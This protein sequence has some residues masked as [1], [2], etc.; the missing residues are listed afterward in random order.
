MTAAYKV[1]GIPMQKQSSR[2]RLVVVVYAALLLLCGTSFAMHLLY[3]Q[4]ALVPYS[5]AIYGSL[6]V[7]AFLFG[8][9]GGF[10]G[11][12]GLVKPFANKPPRVEPPIVTLVKLQ[13]QPEALLHADES[14]WRNDERELHRRDRA[15]YQAYQAVGIGVVV[16][17]LLA[18]WGL[19]PR[20][21]VI[22]ARVLQNVLFFVALITCVMY[23][24]LPAAIILWNEPDMDLG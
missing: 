12:W 15:H 10:G 6:A 20:Q 11:R 24:T 17:L 13:L 19:G 18:F 21:F 1:L 9:T 22:P 16:M 23:M 14:G 2:R 8:G 3:G 7:G 5:V 4:N